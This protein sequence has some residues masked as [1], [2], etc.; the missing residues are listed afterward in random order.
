MFVVF[1]RLFIAFSLMFIDFHAFSMFFVDVAAF[2]SMFIDVHVFSLFFVEFLILLL[3]VPR[4]SWMPN[5]FAVV[6]N[7]YQG[8]FFSL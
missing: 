1:R 6:C 2:S 3:D 8:L 4:C 7:D 5:E